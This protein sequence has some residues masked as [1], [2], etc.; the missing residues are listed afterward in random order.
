VIIMTETITK[1]WTKTNPITPSDVE[2]VVTVAKYDILKYL[3][4]RRLLGMIAIEALVLLLITA[5]PPLLGNSYAKTADGFMNSYAMF[6][7]TLIVIGATLF[8]GDAIVSEFQGRTGYLLFPNPVK[9]WTLLA[10]KF[11]ASVGAMFAVLIIYY[12]V[13]LVMGLAI[14]GGFSTLG[15]ESLLIAMMY[16]VA[17]LAVGYLVSSFMKGS[18]GALILTFALFLFIFSIVTQVLSL[19]KVDPWFMLTFAGQTIGNIIGTSSVGGA[20]N[21][22]AF[23]S[24]TF[25]PD[26][27]VSLGVMVAYTVAALLL[28]YFIFNRR[29]MSA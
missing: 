5:L 25:V 17:A 7:T 1:N 24:S 12:G 8:A 14:T 2:Q 4:S 21:G 10:G 27:E 9:R 22:S 20:G 23:A 3:R 29:E 11:I 19:G 26:I 16:S 13:A 6:V 18:T 28:S 15:V